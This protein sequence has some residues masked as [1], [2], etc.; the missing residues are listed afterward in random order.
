MASSHA[1]SPAV[2]GE[3]LAGAGLRSGIATAQPVTKLDGSRERMDTDE[4]TDSQRFPP[5]GP[6]RAIASDFIGST[7]TGHELEILDPYGHVLFLESFSYFTIIPFYILSWKKL[8][9]N[10]KNMPFFTL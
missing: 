9:V 4:L 2:P 10:T 6:P 1:A 5:G 8:T 3:I 7:S